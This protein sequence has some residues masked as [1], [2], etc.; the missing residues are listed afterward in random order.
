M[1][2]YCKNC[3]A[4]QQE[5]EK[6]KEQLELNTANAVVVDYATR[7]HEYKQALEEIEEVAKDITEKD[8]YENSDA[9]ASKILDI[10]SKAKGGE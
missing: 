3:E 1:S 10:I 7:L 5:N 6:L 9:K 2:E 4:L 8:C